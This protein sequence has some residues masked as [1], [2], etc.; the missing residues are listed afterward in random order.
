MGVDE[1]GGISQKQR[2]PHVYQFPQGH[3]WALCSGSSS[4]AQ[5]LERGS[6]QQVCPASNGQQSANGS[7]NGL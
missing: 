6:S 3:V 7:R 2:D 1:P 5:A 4:V